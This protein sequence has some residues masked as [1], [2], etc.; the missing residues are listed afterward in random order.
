MIFI[1]ACP[2]DHVYEDGNE[3]EIIF[4]Q[5]GKYENITKIVDIPKD[6]III[7]KIK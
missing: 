5:E 4:N 2:F 3:Y 7:T 6:S 1:N